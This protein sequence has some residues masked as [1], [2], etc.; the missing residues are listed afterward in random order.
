[1]TALDQAIIKAYL[2]RGGRPAVDEAELGRAVHPDMAVDMPPRPDPLPT[3]R[4]G[5]IR[6]HV[7]MVRAASV[8]FDALEPPAGLSVD[9][10]GGLANP[11][12]Q[13]AERGSR[14]EPRPAEIGTEP[15]HA[16]PPPTAPRAGKVEPRLRVDAVCWPRPSRRLRQVAC[17]QIER[18]GDAVREAAPP[19]GKVVGVV[20]FSHG[21][22]C[23]TVL[24]A[25]AIRLAELG[26]RTLLLDGDAVQPNL[27]EQLALAAEMGWVDAAMGRVP[28]E[29]AITQSDSE[30]V[31]ILPY[32]GHASPDLALEPSRQAIAAMLHR[33]RPH[34]DVILVDLGGALTGGAAAAENLAEQVDFVFSVQNVQISTPD[35]LAGLRRHLR[36]IGLRETGVI[37]NFVESVAASS[38][39]HA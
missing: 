7:G 10:I 3:N 34:Y 27:A 26:Q 38:S 37:E 2:R 25:I 11:A 20:G 9:P 6:P 14:P 18:L 39:G 24:L 12:R 33:V 8:P 29:D 21:E 16:P 35:R 31:A 23:T 4:P 19:G 32:R 15:V 30:P 22:G 28:L 13:P 5:G 1:M 36:R 17:E